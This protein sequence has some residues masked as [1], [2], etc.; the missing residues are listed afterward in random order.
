M[1]DM[2]SSSTTIIT[3]QD[4]YIKPWPYALNIKVVI[5]ITIKLNNF[6]EKATRDCLGRLQKSFLF[7]GALQ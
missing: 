4:T 7:Q 1:M 5:H 6:K 3:L 2:L